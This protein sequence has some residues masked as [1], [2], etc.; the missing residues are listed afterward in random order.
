MLGDTQGN[1]LT[2][3]L[4]AVSSK[5]ARLQT[6]LGSAVVTLA[7]SPSAGT[8]VLPCRA[9]VHSIMLL[10]FHAV[11][12]THACLAAHTAAASV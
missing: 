2:W 3:S 10:Q 12:G 5:P 9:A 4:E 8:Q 1:V 11:Y 7:V 6:A